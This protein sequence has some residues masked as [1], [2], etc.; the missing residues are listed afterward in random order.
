MIGRFLAVLLCLA[1]ASCIEVEV[2]VSVEDDGSATSHAEIA[3]LPIFL[4]ELQEFASDVRGQGVEV[5][6]SQRDDGYFVAVWNQDGIA[7]SN[8][9]SCSGVLMW[10]TCSFTYFRDATKDVEGIPPE[11]LAGVSDMVPKLNFVV[12]LPEGTKIV[13]NNATEITDTMGMPTLFW[14]QRADQ[15]PFDVR[16][17]VRL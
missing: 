6:I 17:E 1:V 10:K 8:D 11:V 14:N 7:L 4:A 16:F 13:E 12:F 5:K 9:W 15:G 2:I 3:V